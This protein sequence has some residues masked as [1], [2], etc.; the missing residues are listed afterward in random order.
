MELS[1]G[2][3]EEGQDYA[4]ESEVESRKRHAL[5][6]EDG[7]REGE[8][9]GRKQKC[10]AVSPDNKRCVMKVVL[11]DRVNTETAKGRGQDLR[12]SL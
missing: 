11:A 10:G 7:E 5:D 3:E 2:E 9:L 6:D 1:T 12:G 8:T 4:S